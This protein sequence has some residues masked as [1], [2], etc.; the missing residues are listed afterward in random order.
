MVCPR[1]LVRWKLEPVLSSAAVELVSLGS[2][3]AVPRLVA[4]LVVPRPDYRLADSDV[5][6]SHHVGGSCGHCD[7]RQKHP[8]GGRARR[9]RRPGGVRRHRHARRVSWDSFSELLGR[10]ILV[11]GAIAYLERLRYRQVH[12]AVSVALTGPRQEA[13]PRWVWSIVAHMLSSEALESMAPMVPVLSTLPVQL[14]PPALQI[15][16]QM[17]VVLGLILDP[18]LGFGS[19]LLLLPGVDASD[20]E[21][22]A[23]EGK[24]RIEDIATTALINQIQATLPV[25]LQHVVARDAIGAC[26]AQQ[27]GANFESAIEPVGRVVGQNRSDIDVA[28]AIA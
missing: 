12:S 5:A 19:D 9:L 20:H 1:L 24:I 14:T 22:A 28:I 25:L 23:N 3:I 17:M 21:P 2:R 18:A 16:A 6:S 4:C 26:P 27:P 11:A 13:L 8:T 10:A 15:V 7:H